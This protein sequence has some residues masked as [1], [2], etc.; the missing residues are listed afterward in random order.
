M[1]KQAKTAGKSSA[2]SP[3]HSRTKARTVVMRQYEDFVW[4]SEANAAPPSV[5]STTRGTKSEGSPR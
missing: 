2:R 1:K 5:P 4:Y 3:R